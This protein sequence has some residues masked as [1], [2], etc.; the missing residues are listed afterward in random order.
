MHALSLSHSLSLTLSLS[1]SIA[2]SGSALPR[3]LSLIL[4]Y[5][6][7]K[8]AKLS[9]H[10]P[11]GFKKR[12][13][14]F[15]FLRWHSNTLSPSLSLSLHLSP[16]V[17]FC[18]CVLAWCVSLSALFRPLSLSVALLP[19]AGCGAASLCLS[20]SHFGSHT[21]TL[22]RTQTCHLRALGILIKFYDF[23]QLECGNY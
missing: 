6:A 14:I 1:L 16:R 13:F 17:D 8:T 5:A 21:H 10:L 18:M 23:D 11:C 2:L 20:G 9:A 3:Y 15:P 7:G 22:T 12:F 19:F 4:N